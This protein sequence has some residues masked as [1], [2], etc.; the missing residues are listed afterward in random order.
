MSTAPPA[1]ES[2]PRETHGTAE[3]PKAEA[4]RLAHWKLSASLV[5]GW[6]VI[7]HATKYWA[8]VTLKPDWWGVVRPTAEM[9][10]NRP[11]I[12]V[13][14]GFL[15]FV[16]GENTGA[17]FSILEGQTTLLG[18]FSLVAS[19]AMAWYWYTLP[20]G[21]IWGRAAVALI[22]SGAVGNMIDRFFRGFVV[23]FIDAYVGSYHWPTFNIAD[24]CICV[25]AAILATRFLQRKI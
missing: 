15:R 23:D 18:V 12:D 6:F 21:E 3:A 14:P 13:I 10:A 8:E 7:D 11:A 19:V 22:F 20:R 25:G 5:V 24:S 17:A 1:E 16:Y 4:G 9:F 2:Q